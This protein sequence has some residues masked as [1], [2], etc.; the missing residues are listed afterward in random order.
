MI[1][2]VIFVEINFEN[3]IKVDEYQGLLVNLKG[4]DKLSDVFVCIKRYDI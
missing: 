2:Y 1:K 4:K 3:E